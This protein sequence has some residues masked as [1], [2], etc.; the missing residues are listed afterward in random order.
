M[1]HYIWLLPGGKEAL[2]LQQVI[3]DLARGFSQSVFPAHLTLWSGFCNPK[4]VQE[5]IKASCT[6]LPIEAQIQQA[7]FGET[8]FQCI[9]LPITPNT[10][11]STLQ[12]LACANFAGSYNF[13][14]HLSV[15]YL[16]LIHI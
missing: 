3:N 12:Q 4:S 5:R 1:K 15:L 9:Y 7:T 16:S 14:P 10:E 11:L 6:R 8:Y 2:R 13:S